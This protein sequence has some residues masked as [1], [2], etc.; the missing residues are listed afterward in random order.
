L[1]SGGFADFCQDAGSL[2]LLEADQWVDLLP[3]R[4]AA[5]RA[6]S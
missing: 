6:E 4:K 1:Y 5:G 3:A 2:P